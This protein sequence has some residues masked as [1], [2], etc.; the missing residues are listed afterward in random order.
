MASALPVYTGP[1]GPEQAERLLWRA[2]FGP[3]SG[4]AEQLAAKGL[5]GAVDSLVHPPATDKLV[6]KPPVVDGAPIAPKDAFGHDHLWWLDK[7]VRTSRPLV[8]RM[9]LIWHDWFATSN[10]T[11]GSQK[12]MLQQN[13][14]FR[15]DRAR[16]VRGARDARDDQPG[17]AALPERAELDQGLAERELR[18]R[19]DGALHA[20]PRERLHRDATSA[21]RPA[22]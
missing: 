6:G 11:V 3:R 1:F 2:G 14:L 8:E 13:D 17:D 18:A 10:V 7:M 22:R 12:L 21:S 4:E 9:T 19:D 16:L 20:R 15:H 5:Q